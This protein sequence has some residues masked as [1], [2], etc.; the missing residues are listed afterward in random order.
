MLSFGQTEI[1]E[2]KKEA[3]KMKKIIITV[4]SLFLCTSLFAN[5]D[6]TKTSDDYLCGPEGLVAL[7]I[8]KNLFP[9]YREQFN[10]HPANRFEQQLERAFE[11]ECIRLTNFCEG[12]KE[13]SQN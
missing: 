4:A 11:E 1:V 12:Q 5:S 7:C 10:Q 6:T 9:K 3:I 2:V 8:Q 13:P